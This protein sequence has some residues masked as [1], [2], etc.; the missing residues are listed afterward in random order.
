MVTDDNNSDLDANWFSLVGYIN[1]AFKSKWSVA[2]RLEYFDDK[3]GAIYG[4]MPSIIGN[5]LSFNY[6]EGN[7]TF[8]PEVRFDSSS[9]DIFSK[10]DGSAAGSSAYVLLATTYS[11]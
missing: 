2:Y 3:D 7:F 5:T 4:A 8:I 6:K 10:K 11:F 1:Y 9:E